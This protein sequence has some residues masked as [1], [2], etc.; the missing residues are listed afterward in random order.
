LLSVLAIV[1]GQRFVAMFGKKSPI[2]FKLSASKFSMSRET[3]SLFIP[4]YTYPM[5]GAD[6]MITIFCDFCQFWAK[7]LAFLEQQCND[8]VFKQITA[9]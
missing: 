9:F 3:L 6:V 1:F 7:K 4:T 8:Q 2:A 5:S